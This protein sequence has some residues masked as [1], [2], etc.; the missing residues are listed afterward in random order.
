MYVMISS[1]V[2]CIHDAISTMIISAYKSWTNMSFFENLA[3]SKI[4]PL[5]PLSERAGTA[6]VIILRDCYISRITTTDN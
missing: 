5:P 1:N 6:Q 4:Y 3:V 2:T